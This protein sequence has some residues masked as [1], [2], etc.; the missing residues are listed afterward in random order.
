M[1]TASFVASL[2]LLSADFSVRCHNQANVASGLLEGAIDAADRVFRQVRIGVDWQS[3]QRSGDCDMQIHAF[4]VLVTAS[5]ADY[6]DAKRFRL[7]ISLVVPGE[8]SRYAKIFLPRVEQFAKS[9]DVPVSTVLGYAMAHEISHLVTGQVTHSPTGIMKATWDS[10]DRRSLHSNR[11]AFHPQEARVMRD[12]IREQSRRTIARNTG[13][14]EE[15][16]PLSQT[17]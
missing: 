11:L 6:V 1:I 15:S 8:A 7:G 13:R 4:D 10:E 16:A 12:R 2:A 3:C 14:T 17:P 9:I 5:A